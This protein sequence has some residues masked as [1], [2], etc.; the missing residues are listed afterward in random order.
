M[1]ARRDWSRTQEF[2]D[3][4]EGLFQGPTGVDQEYGSRMSSL[5][6]EFT[7]MSVSDR[8]FLRV[9]LDSGGGID[10]GS[11]QT[12]HTSELR[13]RGS[14]FTPES[15]LYHNPERILRTPSQAPPDS[16]FA[17]RPAHRSNPAPVLH[18]PLSPPTDAVLAHRPPG[19]HPTAVPHTWFPPPADS[20]YSHRRDPSYNNPPVPQIPA[21]PASGFSSPVPPKLGFFSGEGHK[22]EASYPQWRSEVESVL[23]T[24][25]YSE[26]MVITNV[27][28][29]LRGRAA[30]VVLAMGSD[31]TVRQILDKFD[32]RFGDI[33][34]T[35]VTLEQFFTAR[36]LP[37]ESMA[38]WG[39][40]LEDLLSRVRDPSSASAARSMLRSRYW[41]GIYSD[42]FRNALR[43]HFDDGADFESL[44]KYA[45]IA[46]QEPSSA[47][48][49]QSVAGTQP[50]KLDKILAQLKDLNARVQ[51]LERKCSYGNSS[52]PMG[53]QRS[54]APTSVPA[55]PPPVSN[56]RP[57]K[58]K[59][60]DCGIV[61][62]R[63][64]SPECPGVV[65]SVVIQA[66]G[67]E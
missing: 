6:R 32:V 36:Q 3:I 16:V 10:R 67:N 31:V 47:V 33:F 25:I 7:R 50:D 14:S 20:G 45:R 55:V 5:V 48:A 22:N 60:Y 17:Q 29:S 12:P 56:S 44:L 43:H 53:V 34:P 42:R 2:E 61:G 19:Y 52:V 58:G 4:E 39:C 57:F 38:A 26:A 8:E 11:P 1:A 64:G 41:S 23:K 28:R 35:D 49:Q 24:G 18:S 21:P 13:Y 54:V 9:L 27:R 66:Q 59:C 15:E 63:R 40:R 30:D 65:D 51:E 62:H 37:N 46:E